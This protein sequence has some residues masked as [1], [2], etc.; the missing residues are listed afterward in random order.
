M[1][2]SSTDECDRPVLPVLWLAFGRQ[3]RCRALSGAP[4]I[5]LLME[6]RNS[7]GRRV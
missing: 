3:Q 2:N 1:R 6:G 7:V 4:V 5:R